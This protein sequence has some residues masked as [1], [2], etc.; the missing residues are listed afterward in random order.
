MTGKKTVRDI[1]VAGKTALVRVDFNVPFRPSTTEISDDSRIRAS[2]PTIRHL[3]DRRCRVV[4]CSHLGRPKG[5]VVDGLRV[6][7]VADR[8]AELLGR[9][10]ATAADCVGPRVADQVGKLSAGEVLTLENLRFHPEEERNDRGFAEELA[11][12]AE[13]YVNDAF[14]ASHRVHASTVGVAGF[15]PAVAGLLM[16]RELEMLGNALHTPRRPFVAILGGKKVSDKMA[17]L[18][19]LITKVDALLIGG[20]MAATFLR[21]RGLETGESPTDDDQVPVAREL[22][23]SARDRG[24]ELIV[25]VDVVA[26]DAFSET[27]DRAVVD[28]DDIPPVWRIM[29]IG[30]RTAALF[31]EALAPAKTVVWN[32]PMGVHE[33]KPFAEGTA[34]IAR[35]LARAR[36]ATTVLGGGSTAEAVAALGLTDRMCHVSTGGGASLEFLGGKELPGVAALLDHESVS[37]LAKEG[38]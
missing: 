3:I 25:P 20:G 4:L 9:P 31:E 18:R 30:P 1:D 21:A 11:S 32:G 26:A 8:L 36:D 7:P 12:L 33:W 34:R 22:S 17:A 10:V 29:D 23:S 38:A 27:A 13:V 35:A 16:V 15:L 6:G 2:L 24:V 37:G 19:N 14:G 5:R 28:V